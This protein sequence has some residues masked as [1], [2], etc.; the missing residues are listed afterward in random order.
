M[1]RH[2]YQ[3][4]D[5]ERAW[6]T[7][8]GLPFRRTSQEL[9]Q[10]SAYYLAGSLGRTGFSYFANGGNPLLERR[11]GDRTEEIL[12][13]GGGYDPRTRSMQIRLVIH[14][15]DPAV[16]KIREVYWW[17]GGK[18]PHGVATGDAGELDLPPC[19]IIW[20]F[21]SE[22]STLAD[23]STVLLENVVPWFDRFDS[24]EEIQD[25]LLGPGIPLVD[26]QTAVEIL[27]AYGN[28]KAAKG[29]LE[30]QV[31]RGSSISTAFWEEF[32]R[33]GEVRVPSF[34][35]ATPSH[36]L[37]HLARRYRLV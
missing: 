14:M 8:V 3:L 18:V 36:R 1:K 9:L 13:R 31:F 17:A 21:N 10:R 35:R 33:I 12:I 16:R 6:S 15:S 32:R 2:Y 11:W 28:R 7:S 22:T 25:A 4:D 27:L 34:D 26:E 5:W 30:S 29:Y 24:C 19:R 37:A 23:M 20:S